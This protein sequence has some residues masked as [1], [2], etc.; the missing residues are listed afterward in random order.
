M[1]VR[2]AAFLRGSD[3][4]GKRL[5]H[6]WG[7]PS[8][9]GGT[10]TQRSGMPAARVLILEQRQSGDFLLLRF[11][12]DGTFAGDTWHATLEDGKSQSESEYPGLVQEWWDIPPSVADPDVTSFVLARLRERAE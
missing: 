5:L 1:K 4:T 12:G 3:R 6:Y 9:L 10:D 2:Q 8:E 11:A 7:L